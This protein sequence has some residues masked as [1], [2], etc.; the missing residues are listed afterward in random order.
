KADGTD[1]GISSLAGLSAGALESGAQS[2]MAL[3]QALRDLAPFE[4]AA[5]PTDADLPNASEEWISARSG[6]LSQLLES[7]TADRGYALAA[8]N[9]NTRFV[10]AA[11]DVS[12]SAITPSADIIARSFSGSESALQGYLS[13]LSY[14]T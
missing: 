6:F 14:G 3:R 8:T 1:W 5:A 13:G 10:D 2:D 11:Q 7:R 12:L 9:Q 4:V